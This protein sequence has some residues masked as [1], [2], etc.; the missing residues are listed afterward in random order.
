MC[1][2]IWRE[3]ADDRMWL[4]MRV[5]CDNYDDEDGEDDSMMMMMMVVVVVTIVMV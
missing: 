2:V 5:G 1:Q 4:V 3:E